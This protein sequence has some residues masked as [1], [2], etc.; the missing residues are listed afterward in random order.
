M[1]TISLKALNTYT[2]GYDPADL[3]YILDNVNTELAVP[4]H[5]VLTAAEWGI[6]RA[7]LNAIKTHVEHALTR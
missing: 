2:E 7:R 5:G 1:E 6:H 3:R 4:N